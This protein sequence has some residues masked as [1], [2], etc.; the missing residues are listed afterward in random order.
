MVIL[1]KWICYFKYG[2]QNFK[3]IIWWINRFFWQ[4]HVIHLDHIE[5]VKG[6]TDT[7]NQTKMY[8]CAK[9]KIK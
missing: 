9:N 7:K 1:L 2:G 4:T 3:W 6:K 5:H 8:E